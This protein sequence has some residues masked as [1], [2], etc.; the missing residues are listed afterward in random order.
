MKSCRHWRWVFKNSRC[1]CYAVR[2]SLIAHWHSCIA[3]RN[4]SNINVVFTSAHTH[5]H[6]E[7]TVDL[8][9]TQCPCAGAHPHIDFPTP[10]PATKVTLCSPVLAMM[11]KL[12]R[13][14]C[15]DSD[16]NVAQLSSH[17]HKHTSVMCLIVV[18]L[19]TAR[20]TKWTENM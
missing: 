7:R 5:T 4:C 1:V 17:K 16:N 20:A 19:F 14:H 10:T 9:I 18:P 2:K 6:R 12:N 15:E 11:H 8:S 13:T 3:S